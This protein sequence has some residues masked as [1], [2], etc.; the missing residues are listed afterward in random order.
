MAANIAW[1]LPGK[2]ET[3]RKT[4]PRS[5]LI[6]THVNRERLASHFDDHLAQP[7]PQSDNTDLSAK[8]AGQLY[9]KTTN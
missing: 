5:G 2:A 9:D 4:N 8:Q 7:V 3:K 1:G 6:R